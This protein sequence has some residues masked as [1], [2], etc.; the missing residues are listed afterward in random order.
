MGWFQEKTPVLRADLRLSV[1]VDLCPRTILKRVVEKAR[2]AN[3]DFLVGFE[4][5]FILLKSTN[6]VEAANYHSWSASNG[7]LSGSTEALV[8]REIADSIQASGIELQMYHPEAAPGQYEMV[9]GP[10]PPLESADALVHTREIITNTAAKHGLRATFAPRI[11]MDSTGSSTHTHISIHSKDNVKSPDRLSSYESYFLS[12]VLAHLPAL[13]ALT[14]PTPASFQR[15]AD[16]IWAGGTYVCYGTEHRDVPMRITN[17]SSPSSR[18]FE[19]RVI[20]GTANPYLVLA[21]V[22][23][24]GLAGIRDKV[25]LTIQDCGMESAA[26]MTEAIRKELGITQRM[27]LNWE[28][29]R[30]NF[31]ESKFLKEEIF[32]EEFIEKYLSVNKTLG[33]ALALDG[34]DEKASLMRLVEFY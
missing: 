25:E 27:P 32:G 19:M 34:D 24:A 12:S 18:N 11:Y 7:F 1:E 4:S 33:E 21:G 20:D 26:H 8:L 10:L 2:N 22:L 13:L 23:G 3:V 5:E 16:G 9:T 14:Y 31:K 17:F 30:H 28:D 15:M 6:P 29:S